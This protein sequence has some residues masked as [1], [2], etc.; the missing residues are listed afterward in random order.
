M[1]NRI[2]ELLY[3][4][5][6]FIIYGII[7]VSGATLDFVVFYVLA[8]TLSVHYAVATALST[9]LGIVNNFIWNVLF[10]FKTKDNIIKRFVSFYLVGL[11][12]LLL[13]I[14]ILYVCVDI[15]HF[16]KNISK[17]FTIFVIVLLQYNLNKRV[18]FKTKDQ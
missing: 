1:V 5:R 12:G 14:A 7:G 3:S 4:Y 9:S 13:S 8:N 17:L 11:T 16:N 6:Q 15:M 18:S 10:N 2:K